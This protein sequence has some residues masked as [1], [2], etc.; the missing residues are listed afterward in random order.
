MQVEYRFSLVAE[1]GTTTTI[2]DWG[3]SDTCTIPDGQLPE[4]SSQVEVCVRR[5]GT[6]VGYER[7]CIQDISG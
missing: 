1:D 6:T 4:G 3:A 5:A 2:Q 7:Y